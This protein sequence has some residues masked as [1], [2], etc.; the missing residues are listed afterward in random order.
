MDLGHKNARR[1]FVAPSPLSRLK[2]VIA[3]HANAIEILFHRRSLSKCQLQLYDK[4]II[5]ERWHRGLFHKYLNALVA[6]SEIN[7]VAVIGCGSGKSSDISRWLE[8][9]IKNIDAY[10]ISNHET[11]ASLVTLFRQ[12][13]GATVTFSNSPAECPMEAITVSRLMVFNTATITC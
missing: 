1:K 2:D 8:I 12:K 10:E 11:W 3:P 5:G 6:L 9:G 4:Y 13:H 7:R